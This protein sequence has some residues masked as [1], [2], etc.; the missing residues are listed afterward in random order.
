MLNSLMLFVGI[1]LMYSTPLV[2]AA[3]G[4]VVSE[5]SGVTNIGIE[6][7]MT[8]GAVTGATVGYYSGSAWVGFFAAGLAG[9]VIA[10]LHAFAS[11]T[12]KADQT[13]SGIAI[14]LIGPGVA[15]FV[16][17]LLFDGAT[18]SLPV[19]HKIPKV[20]GSLNSKAFQNLNVDVTVV[21]AFVLAVFIWFF[22]YKTKW[23]LHIRAVGEHPAAADTMGLN[24]YKIRYICVLVSGILAGLGGASMTLAI[25]PQFT[26]TAIS[27]QGFIALAAV[28]FG[29]WTPH[30]AYGA[31]LLFGAAQA[32]T[33]T[34]GG[35]RF[36]V[37][38]SILAMLPYLIT[39]VILILFVGKSSAPK[40]SGQPYEKDAR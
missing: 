40:A 37:P 15:L 1:T 34:L 33:V 39:I 12:C 36:A 35:G 30:G 17:R 26:P 16:C 2:F 21:I 8:I 6:G 31:C 9:G 38:S 28:I 5:R 29:K 32:L 4:G 18:M 10:L 7:M 14:N 22:L 24:V 19:P 13:I 27:G 25:I 23:G 11:I 20:F 3:L